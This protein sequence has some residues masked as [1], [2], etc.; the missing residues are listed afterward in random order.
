M[1]TDKPRLILWGA[2]TPRT[3]RVHWMLHEVGLDYETRAISPRTPAT[4]SPE[5]T[6]LNPVQKIPV[7]EDGD[8]TL[9]ESAA[10]VT[11]LAENYGSRQ[12]LVPPVSSSNRAFYYQWCFFVMTEIDAYALQVIFKHTTRDEIFGE[13]SN[14]VRAAREAFQ[15]H[16]SMVHDALA[17]GGPFILGDTFTGADI[18][19]STSLI[20]ACN[21]DLTLSGILRDYLQLTTAR[22]AYE[23]ACASN[24]I[25]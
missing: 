5:F 4:Q 16:G 3:L 13:A 17:A 9:V 25:V 6:R 8:L 7:L 1:S 19:L 15:R 11:H 23:R 2:G 14:A 12:G 21:Y 18:L 20:W 22:P 24:Q 10:I